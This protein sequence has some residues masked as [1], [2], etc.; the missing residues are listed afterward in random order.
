MSRSPDVKTTVKM[1]EHD[2]RPH[3]DREADGST[4]SR[5]FRDKDHSSF[6]EEALDTYGADGSIDPAAEKKLVRKIDLL[7]LPLLGIWCAVYYL[8]QSLF[9]DVSR[10]AATCL[11]ALPRSGTPELDTDICPVSSTTWTRQPCR[12]PR[13]LA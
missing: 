12:T 10:H 6:Y 11:C 1:I 3:L 2:L 9:S 8:I 5:M 13:Y 7:I 4:F